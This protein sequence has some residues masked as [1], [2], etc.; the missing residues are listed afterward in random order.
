VTRSALGEDARFLPRV[1][2][3]GSRHDCEVLSVL[4]GIFSFYSPSQLCISL[5]VIRAEDRKT[6]D[7]CG[8]VSRHTVCKGEERTRDK[9]HQDVSGMHASLTQMRRRQAAGALV[10]GLFGSSSSMGR[11]AAFSAAD[12]AGGAIKTTSEPMSSDDNEGPRSMVT[13]LNAVGL[14]P[15]D[16]DVICGRGGTSSCTFRSGATRVCFALRGIPGG[17]R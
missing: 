15:G 3:W 16:N 6:H 8:T 11:S 7:C 2:G 17:R 1:G 12:R 9:S 13:A 4:H 14:Q 5:P 10:T